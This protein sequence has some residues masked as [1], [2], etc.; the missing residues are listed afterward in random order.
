MHAIL[1]GDNQSLRWSD[2]PEPQPGPGDIV[3]DIRA[4]AVNRADLMQR[5]GNYPPPPGWP[6]WMGL[7]CAGIVSHA[8]AGGRWQ[9]GDAVCAL[10]GGGGYAE[11]VALPADMAMA[12]PKGLSMAEAA[13]LPEVY[14]TAYLNL[15]L[16]AG[17]KEGDTVFIQAGASGLGTAAVQLVKTMGGK[18]VTTVGSD[19]KATFV[20]QLGAD[21]V[22]NHRSEDVLA[23]LQA[24]PCDIALD[25]V[26]GADMGKYLETMNRSGRW[27]M[28][29]TLGGNL[30][31]IDLGKFFRTGLRLI[32]STLRSRPSEM[33]AEILGGLEKLLWPAF[34]AGSIKPILHAT[35]PIE[36][37]DEAH[38]ILMRR[39]NLGKVVL[40]V[41]DAS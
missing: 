18:V 17:L 26:G 39:E 19:D 36:Q 6:E 11:R 24:N 32:G 12:V 8:P 14:A 28:I 5:A 13:A 20:K 41:G 21:V 9:V 3:V 27:V 34:E 10:L 30:T 15:C 29:A 33:K 40:T 38:G 37:A 2:V 22:I 16:E 23:V 25:C 31:E 1:V 35:L 7:E 4:T